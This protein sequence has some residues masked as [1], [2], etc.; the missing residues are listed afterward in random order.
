MH[1]TLNTRARHLLTLRYL[2]IA[3][4]CIVSYHRNNNNNDNNSNNNNNN[5][6]NNNNNDNNNNN[7][8]NNAIL[9]R[10]ASGITL[11]GSRF[12]SFSVCI[13]AHTFFIRSLQ[14]LKHEVKC[15][16]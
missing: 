4:Y 7:N 15:P 5:D 6:N 11:F 12:R 16:H 3:D 14:G 13:L 8:N 1:F 2:L 9:L 10:K